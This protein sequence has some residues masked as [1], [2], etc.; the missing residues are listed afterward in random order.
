MMRKDNIVI[1]ICFLRIV[2]ER[3]SALP[4]SRGTLTNDSTKGERGTG[5]YERA[6][7]DKKRQGT[8]KIAELP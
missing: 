6:N 3:R 4:G 7:G 1:F 2:K 5:K 8:S